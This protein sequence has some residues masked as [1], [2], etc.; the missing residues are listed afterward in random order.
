[1]CRK[2]THRS[3]VFDVL[4]PVLAKRDDVVDFV[5]RKRVR[6]VGGHRYDVNNSAFK[7]CFFFFFFLFLCLLFAMVGG[8]VLWRLCGSR[9][10]GAVQ[11]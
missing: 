6:E 4:L 7:P 10:R 5:Q 1:M 8:G 3:I 9:L 11:V 2:H